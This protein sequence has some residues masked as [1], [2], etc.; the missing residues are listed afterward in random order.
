TTVLKDAA[1]ASIYGARAAN[2][3][4]VY[5]TKKGTKGG[6]P[7]E[8]TFDT[9]VGFTTPGEGQA[10]MNPQDFAQWTWNAVI[11][12]AN[13]NGDTP[14]FTHP[15]FGTGSSPDLPDYLLVGASGGVNGS[16]DLQAERE[17]YNVTN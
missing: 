16:V 11:N 5:T 12:T 13:A 10:M 14:T 1:T 7:M 17:N 3:V 6:K 15:Q 8:V 9:M 4:I 2:G